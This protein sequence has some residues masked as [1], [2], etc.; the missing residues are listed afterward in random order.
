MGP[1][2]VW[3]KPNFRV[4]AWRK[5][6]KSQNVWKMGLFP[7]KIHLHLPL[8]CLPPMEYSHTVGKCRWGTHQM[9]VAVRRKKIVLYIGANV[10]VKLKQAITWGR[11]WIGHVWRHP[12]RWPQLQ[13][14]VDHS[15]VE[16]N[17]ER[18]SICTSPVYILSVGNEGCDL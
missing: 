13:Q 11:H 6:P 12:V 1:V 10:R 8:R 4:C 5:P 2:F 15:R 7:R 14:L 3:L 17:S 16:L 9:S 18:R